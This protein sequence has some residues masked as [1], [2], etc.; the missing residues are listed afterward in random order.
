MNRM[1]IKKRISLKVNKRS[2]LTAGL[3]FCFQTMT[4]RLGELGDGL[5]EPEVTARQRELREIHR[6][7]ALARFAQSQ[8]PFFR[9]LIWWLVDSPERRPEIDWKGGSPGGDPWAADRALVLAKEIDILVRHGLLTKAE[10]KLLE[11]Q[12]S[13]RLPIDRELQIDARAAY[14][15]PR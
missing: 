10:R 12:P 2:K 13:A 14:Q 15:P 11:K 6:E 4:D 8:K 7:E 5:S 3:L 1:A 9:P